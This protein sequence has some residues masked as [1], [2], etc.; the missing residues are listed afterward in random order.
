V[1]E[2]GVTQQETVWFSLLFIASVWALIS[3]VVVAASVYYEM[4]GMAWGWTVSFV[5][6][7]VVAAYSFSRWL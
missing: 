7:S 1:G 4:R 2:S 5:L 6:S 3:A